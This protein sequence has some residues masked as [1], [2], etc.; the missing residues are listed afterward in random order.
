M[1]GDELSR[2]MR[3]NV[4]TRAIPVIM[5][6]EAR[7]RA[8]ERQGLESGADAYVSKSAEQALIIL[9]IRALLRRRAAPLA[10]A[11][12][13]RDPPSF[14]AFRRARILI[15]DEEA[16]TT[17][18]SRRSPVPARA[19]RDVRVDAAGSTG[20]CRLR[21]RKPGLRA[22]VSLQSPGF[23]GV[24]LCRRLSALSRRCA[25]AGKWRS[26]PS[27]SSAS[28]TRTAA[29]F[30]RGRFA[31]GADDIVPATAEADVMRV[32]IRAL[33]RRKLLQDENWRIETELQRAGTGPGAGPHG[34]CGGGS[35]S[36]PRRRA[37]KGQSRA[38]RGQPAPE[39]YP[40][41][42][43][44][45]GQDGL[46]GRAGGGHRARD[47]QSAGLHP[48]PSG[49]GRTAARRNRHQAA[50]RAPDSRSRSQNRGNAWRR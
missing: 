12:D 14:N 27:T 29:T 32:R 43:R 4:R 5:L 36:S 20:P 48:G 11:Q 22:L 49:H 38:R 35:A 42:A 26:R 8:V 21:R 23:D 16:R 6:T 10:S 34:G 9:R 13:R 7:E 30:S 3:L 41:Q 25:V 18:V 45:G 17:D 24:E 19:I 28:A 33:V 2:Q 47:Q 44:P 31:A 1:N 15:V 50:R 39:G 46:P 40:G 37:G